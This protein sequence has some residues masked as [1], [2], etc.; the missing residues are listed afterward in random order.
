LNEPAQTE[1]EKEEEE[2]ER[3][4]RIA[5]GNQDRIYGPH[6]KDCEWNV[7]NAHPYPGLP[8]STTS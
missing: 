1:E 4:L 8:V 3:N 7:G 2:E 5:P 6:W